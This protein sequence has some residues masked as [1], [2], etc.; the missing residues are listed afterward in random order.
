MKTLE[1]IKRAIEKARGTIIKE[2]DDGFVHIV[3]DA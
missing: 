1:R 3:L 2:G